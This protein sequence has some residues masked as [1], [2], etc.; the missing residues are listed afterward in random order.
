LPAAIEVACYRIA[1][2]TLTNVVCHA[3]AQTCVLSLAIDE[4]AVP[5]QEVGDDGRGLPELR[6]GEAGQIGVGLTSMRE[7]ATELGGG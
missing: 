1:A 7:R 5:R 3:G 4:G 2:E 6:T